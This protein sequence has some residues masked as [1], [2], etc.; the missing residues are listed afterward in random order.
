MSIIEE[1]KRDAFSKINAEP[2]PNPNFDPKAFNNR[3]ILL[4]ADILKTQFQIQIAIN[5]LKSYQPAVITGACGNITSDI[6]DKFNIDTDGV[7]YMD[8]L[9][10]TAFDDDHYFDQPDLYTE[11]QKISMANNISLYWA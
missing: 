2:D 1:R 8:I 10:N 3:N 6:S 5:I 9:P 4:F 7:T 11:E